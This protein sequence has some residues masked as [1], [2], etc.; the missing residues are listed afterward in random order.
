MAHWHDGTNVVVLALVSNFVPLGYHN[1]KMYGT[2]AQWHR[3]AFG[4]GA[5]HQAGLH[6]SCC[7]V[8]L[9]AAMTKCLPTPSNPVPSL[10][11]IPPATV[12]A[13][14]GVPL[15]TVPAFVS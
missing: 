14:L 11:G 9:L 5:T 1:D 3:L 2:V 15:A 4:A 8:A 12:P 10:L 13:L 7:I 6:C